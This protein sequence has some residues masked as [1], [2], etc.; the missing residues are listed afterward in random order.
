MS[1]VFGENIYYFITVP[2]LNKYKF[3]DNNSKKEII[4]NRILKVKDRFGLENLDYG[5]NS[6]HYHLLSYFLDWKNIPEFLKF[7]NGGSSFE[8]NKLEDRQGR[9]IWD[10]Y[11]LYWINDES[12]LYKIRGYVI[13]NP[14]KH[15]EVNSLEDLFLYKFSSFN[16]VASDIGLEEA[17]KMV[18][19]C[20]NLNFNDFKKKVEKIKKIINLD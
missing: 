12:V 8:L 20:I 4:L 11:H 18:L 14:Y 19:S 1:R 2:T 7:V 6:N 16:N 17:K 10:E 5:I 9:K 15:N 3:F 13:G